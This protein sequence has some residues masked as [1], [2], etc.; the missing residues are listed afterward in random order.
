MMNRP[1]GSVSV[2]LLVPST[3]TTAPTTGSPDT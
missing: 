1:V 3:D 2:R